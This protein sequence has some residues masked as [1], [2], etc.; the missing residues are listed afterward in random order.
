MIVPGDLRADARAPGGVEMGLAAHRG[1]RPG[2]AEY[3]I[4]PKEHG[5]D[6]L[7]DHRH[8]WL[9]SKRQHAILRVRARDHPAVRDFFDAHGFTLVDAPIFT[10]NACEG[11]SHALRDR[12]TSARRRTS[13]S[14]ASSTSRP[15][16]MAFGKVY[17]FGPTF[18]AEKSKTR[19][20]LT[21]FWMVEP[22]V[23]FMDLDGDMDARRGLPRARRAARARTPQRRARDP[24]ARHRAS[25][26]ACR[27]RSRA[28]RYD[29]A[30]DDPR[31]E[32][33]A[34]AK[35]GDDFGGDEETVISEQFDRPVIVH[36]YPAAMKAFYMKRD[37]DE[38]ALA[39]G[40]RRARA[41]GLRRDHRRRPARGRPRHARGAH[42]RAQAA[43]RGVRV[44]PRPA[45]LRHACRTPASGSASSARWRGSAA[46]S[47]CARHPVPAHAEPPAAL[48]ASRS[49]KP[50]K[51]SARL[52]PQASIAALGMCSGRTA[53]L[54][55]PRPERRPAPANARPPSC[56]VRRRT[57]NQSGRRADDVGV[58]SRALS[59][60]AA[61]R[62]ETRPISSMTC[63]GAPSPPGRSAR[64]TLGRPGCGHAGSWRHRRRLRTPPVC[65][66]P[67]QTHNSRRRPRE[68]PCP[69]APSTAA[70]VP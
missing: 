11:T 30:I 51:M 39:L 52:D 62:G 3:P 18:R 6:F 5:T 66:A 12:A 56:N 46:S 43:A 44:V 65:R 17:C 61:T 37:P 1:R 21:E 68:H 41:R 57:T 45:P 4:S 63:T 15:A 20:H 10:P 19:R 36:R 25:S 48:S 24:R 49:A 28:S 55:P 42:R 27:S 60:R 16:A 34:T 7:M 23:A 64:G 35:F 9:R 13:R 29:E 40:V 22:E 59:R 31:E 32:G 14:R 33:Q 54:V 69:P 8:L 53:G 38:P 47:T 50:V 67:R 70:Q 26:R 58:P 2:R